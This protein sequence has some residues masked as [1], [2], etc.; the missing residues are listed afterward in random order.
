MWDQRYAEPEFTYGKAPNDFLLSLDLPTE[1]GKVLCLAEGQGRNAVY[2]AECGF[3]VTAVDLSAVGLQ[4]A[5]ELAAE[6]GATIHTEQADLGELVLENDAWD[7]IVAIFAHL[8]P[9]V[10]RHIHTQVPLGL[11]AGGF[12]VLEAYRKA[13]LQ[14]KTGGPPNEQLLYALEDLKQD[15]GE[16]MQWEIAREVERE[17]V[18][19]KYHTGLAATVQLFGHRS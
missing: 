12:F 10:R 17:V 5:Q 2:L 13:Q 18:E 7:G 6:R 19:G 16:P 11:K 15:F 4:R 3:D 1:G 8:P 14:Y 9:P